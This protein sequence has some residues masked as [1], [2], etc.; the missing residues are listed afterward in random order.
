MVTL[1]QASGRT[2][3]VEY[4]T[5]DD[6]AQAAS[7]YVSVRGALTFSP[8]ETSKTVPVTVLGDTA[9]EG[10]ETF[11]F[12]LSSPSNAVLGTT[13]AL[14]ILKNDDVAIAC[15][16]RPSVASTLQPGNG[17]LNVHVEATPLNTQQ[18]NPLKQLQ[19]GAFT[20]ATVTLNGQ[21]VSSGQ[22]VTLPASTIAADFTVTRVVAGQPSTVHL[23][24]VDGCGAWPTFVGGGAGAGF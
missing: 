5:A 2:V 10:D 8:G 6:T 7:D 19:F 1:S 22:T 13:Q 12:V 16:P 18:N 20:N 11:L 15:T 4:T 3:I 9:F 21:P 23:T 17:K 24:I 14:G